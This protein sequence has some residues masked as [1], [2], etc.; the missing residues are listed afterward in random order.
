MLL[1]LDLST[2]SS[3]F[4]LFDGDKLVDQGCWTA[5]SNNLCKRIDKIVGELEKQLQ[6]HKI[7]A[8]AAEDPLP[9]KDTNEQTH[10]AL[11]WLQGAV[12]LMLDEQKLK[13]DKFQ[14]PSEW[15]KV[16]GIAQGRGIRRE[17]GKENDIAWCKNTFGLDVNDDI[18]DA[19][20]I[21]QAFIHPEN[22]IGA[23][24]KPSAF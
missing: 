17:S 23:D 13:F 3:G 5:S 1:A 9:A 11:M 14:Q 18:A 24:G 8:V 15:R 19:I 22:K 12:G 4:A 7:N 10:R 21:G 20:G 2:K 16:C 6:E